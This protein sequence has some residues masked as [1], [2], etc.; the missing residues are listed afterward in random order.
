MKDNSINQIIQFL[1]KQ[2]GSQN[3]FIIDHWDADRCAI[4]LTNQSSQNLVYLST[5]NK[6]ANECYVELEIPGNNAKEYEV[7]GSFD[8]VNSAELEKIVRQHLGI[9]S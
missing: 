1:Q 9:N 5:Y 8:N 7:N 3:L 6:K 2:I 4:G